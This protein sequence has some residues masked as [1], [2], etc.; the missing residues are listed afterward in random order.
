MSNPKEQFIADLYPAARR[1][2]QETGMS[3]ELILAQAALET[4]WGEKVLPGTNN[5]FNIK[6][7][8][9]WQGESREF[10]VREFVNG[11]WV[12]QNDRFRVYPSIDDALRDR[13]EFL[14]DNPRY[15]RAGLFE[16]GTQGNLRREA[17]ALQRGGYATDPRYADKL[18][19]IFG[20]RTMRNGIALGREQMSEQPAPETPG[21]RAQADTAGEGTWPAPGNRSVNRADKP[22]EGA[23]GWN[24]PRPAHRDGDGHDGVDIQGRVGD[25]IVAFKGGTVVTATFLRGYGNTVDIRHANGDVTRYAHLDSIDARVQPGRSVAEGQQIGRMGQS[26]N[27]PRAGD[28]HLHFEYRVN[29]RD[30]DPM[31][32]LN[33]ATRDGASHGRG[34]SA[35]AMADGVLKPGERGPEVIELQ[36]RLNALGYRGRDGRPLET[37]S[38]IYGPETEHAVREFQRAHD[39]EA[40]GKAGRGETLPAIERARAAPLVSEATHPA[41]GLFADVSG[42]IAGQTGQVPSRDAVANITLQMLENGFRDPQD[43]QGLAVR[44]SNVHVQGPVAGARV[45]VDLQAP[46]PD[47]QSMSDH[48]ARQMHEQQREQQQRQ[49]EQVPVSPALS[50]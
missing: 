34:A 44:G 43:I 26:G 49:R 21:R 15:E 35:G 23:G 47:L 24:T 38:G 4:G 18:V 12:E 46:T 33:G 13:V 22:G 50:G 14:R 31:P 5:I 11:R 3:W 2:G 20:G 42:R 8:A 30:V 9:G 29:G 27:S 40:D 36:T 45:S 1:I 39:L 19:E 6:A 41:H 32:Y 37:R 28:A 17:E 25:P 10:R 16:E 7:D 48:M